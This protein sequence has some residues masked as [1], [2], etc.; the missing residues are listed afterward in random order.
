MM[1]LPLFFNGVTVTVALHSL[2]QILI[3]LICQLYGLAYLYFVPS[4]SG[5]RTDLSTVARRLLFPRLDIPLAA[6]S[7]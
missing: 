4:R 7:Y 1:C 3:N 6:H 5:S 2:M